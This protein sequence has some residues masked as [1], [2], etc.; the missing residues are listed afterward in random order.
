[1]DMLGQSTHEDVRKEVRR[2]LSIIT[3]ATKVA[4]TLAL[5]DEVIQEYLTAGAT[6]IGIGIDSDLL[7]RQS[8]EVAKK[9]TS[10]NRDS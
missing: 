6:F 8:E 1:M 7:A 2:S 3:K 9:W 5:K 10:S 4:G